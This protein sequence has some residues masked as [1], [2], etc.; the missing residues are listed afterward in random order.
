MSFAFA[1]TSVSAFIDES[2]IVTTPVASFKVTPVF[3]PIK[4]QRLSSPLAIVTVRLVSWLS[5][6]VISS[7]FTSAS[8]GGVTVTVPFL[9][10]VTVGALGAVTSFA[11]IEIS[12]EAS[13]VSL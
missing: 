1:F 9:F 6:Y 7:L 2:W 10:A 4:L 11:N 3:S 8:A 12:F 13:L 5:L